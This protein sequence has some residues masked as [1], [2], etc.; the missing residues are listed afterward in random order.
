MNKAKREEMQNSVQTLEQ[1]SRLGWCIVFEY[2]LA[3]LL[4]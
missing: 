4:S 1:P 3:I 2:Y